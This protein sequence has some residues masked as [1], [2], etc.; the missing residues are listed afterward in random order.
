M[1]GTES[2]VNT[3][4]KSKKEGLLPEEKPFALTTVIRVA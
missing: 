3:A 2:V 4:Q 1:D